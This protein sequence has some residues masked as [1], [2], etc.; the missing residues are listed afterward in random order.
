MIYLLFVFICCGYLAYLRRFQKLNFEK[1]LMYASPVMFLWC[2]LIGGQY[3]VGTD[4]FSYLELFVTGDMFYVENLRGE[5]G[6]SYFVKMCH[7]LGIY[8]QGIFFVIAFIWALIFIYVAY[9]LVGSKYL[10]LYLFVYIVF[11]G[12]FNNQM[13]GIR[14]YFAIYILVLA[15]AFL[16]NRCFAKA[17]L[18]FI[19]AP[20]FHQTAVI[21]IL[22]GLFCYFVISGFKSQLILYS[23]ILMGFSVGLLISDETISYFLPYFEQYSD[24]LTRGAVEEQKVILLITKYIYIPLFLGGIYL[25]PKMNLMDFHKRLFVFGLC[26]YALKLSTVSL[27]LVS[28]LGLYLE[29]F[30]CI[31]L[32]YL[33]LYLKNTRKNVAYGFS[34]VYLLLPYSMKVLISTYGEYSYTSYFFIP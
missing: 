29:F 9:K 7:K 28:R 17:L 22:L 8:G 30:S 32:I 13:N 12:G 20:L 31:P 4:Y 18:L 34:I 23:I 2:L 11:T 10:Y 3:N 16:W 26:G 14:Q 25:F 1:T 24:Y 19:L 33:L 21:P 27:A 5:Y 6:F 15:F